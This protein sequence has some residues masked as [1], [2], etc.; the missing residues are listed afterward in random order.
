[1]QACMPLTSSRIPQALLVLGALAILGLALSARSG[2]D[3][4]PISTARVVRQNISSFITTNGKVEPIDPSIIQAQLTT[5]VDSR[6]VK[7]GQPVSRGQL[8]L[9]LDATEARSELARMREQLVAAQ[10]E[11]RMATSGGSPDDRA[12]LGAEL[13]KTNAEISR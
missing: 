10:Y 3:A 1:M 9:T 5:F 8:L 12:E 11:R 2:G 4:V 13:A 6:L 7:E